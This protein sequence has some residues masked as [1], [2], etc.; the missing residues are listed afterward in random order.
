MRRAWFQLLVFLSAALPSAAFA[1]IGPDAS[2]DGIV[3]GFM[4][5]LGGADHLLAMIL[6]GV[7]AF[8]MGRRGAWLLPI[9]FVAL[10][11]FGGLLGFAAFPV[12]HVEIGI[13]ISVIVFG[14][15]VAAGAQA[16]LS[17]AAAVV[18]AFAVLHGHAHGAEIPVAVSLAT[19]GTGFVLATAL[20]HAIG[21]GLGA[22]LGLL[23]ADHKVGPYRTVG[24]LATTAG[25]FLLVGVL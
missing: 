20:L 5:P 10:M 18:G 23:N 13:A 15:M 1:H 9:T 25:V 16:P 6:V 21:L 14:L 12:P 17:L 7:F 11:A 24:S 8:R 22:A 4:H 19:Y 2:Q 3:H